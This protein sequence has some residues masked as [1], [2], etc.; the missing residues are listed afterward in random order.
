[1][2]ETIKMSQAFVLAH[3]YFITKIAKM[4]KKTFFA[5]VTFVMIFI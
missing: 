5:Y 3:L 2:E 1:M 4:L